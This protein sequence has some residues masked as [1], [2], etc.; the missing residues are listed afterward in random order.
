[1]KKI[2]TICFL[3]VCAYTVN[4]QNLTLAETENYINDIFKT[5]QA[6]YYVGPTGSHVLGVKVQKTGKITLYRIWDDKRE[7]NSPIGSFSVFDLDYSK[8][9]LDLYINT[10]EKIGNFVRLAE[11]EATKLIKAFA[12]LKKICDKSSDPFAN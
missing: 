6:V 1:M 11:S 3:L 12:Y 9:G 8:S 2:I 5:N 10:G 7:F 4:A